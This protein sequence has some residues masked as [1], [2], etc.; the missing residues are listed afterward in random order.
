MV[1]APF[2]GPLFVLVTAV[3][4][5]DDDG[6]EVDDLQPVDCLGAEVGVSDDLGA[7]D[8]LREQRGVSFN[9]A[10][11]DA[12]VLEHA[13]LHYDCWCAGRPAI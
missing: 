13:G 5:I 11:I 9:S 4:I 6:W 1:P 3:Q 12:A 2:A 7:G 10:E 8:A